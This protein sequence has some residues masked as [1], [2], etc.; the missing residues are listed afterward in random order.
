MIGH[1]EDARPHRGDLGTVFRTQTGGEDTSR[2]GGTNLMQQARIGDPPLLPVGDVQ[3]GAVGGDP[4]V[5]HGGDPRGQISSRRCG[6]EQDDL[7]VPF[8]SGCCQ[9]PGLRQSPIGGQTIIFRHQHEV[10]AESGCFF[11][12]S[13]QVGTDQKC[14]HASSEMRS[15]ADCVG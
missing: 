11:G 3:V 8:R 15:Q 1:R 14:G 7:W 4:G 12:C 13:I 10:G 9:D 2:H 5:E 6:S